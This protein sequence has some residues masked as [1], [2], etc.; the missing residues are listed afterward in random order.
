[1]ND[2]K[3][4]LENDCKVLRK[5]FEEEFLEKRNCCRKILKFK[6]FSETRKTSLQDFDS[7]TQTKPQHSSN[8]GNMLMI[9]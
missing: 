6:D 9:N 3:M 1:M 5:D 4:A 7:Y 8:G 2:L